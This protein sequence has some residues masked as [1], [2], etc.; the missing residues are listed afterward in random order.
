MNCRN[1]SLE[2]RFVVELA[3]AEIAVESDLLFVNR[4]DV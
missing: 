2:V 3:R 4:F 1:V